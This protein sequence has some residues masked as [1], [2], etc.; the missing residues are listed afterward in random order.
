VIKGLKD[1]QEGEVLVIDSRG[2]RKALTGE[3]FPTEAQRK[4]LAGI[5]IDGPCRDTETVRSLDIPYYARS[6]HCI[7]GTTSRLFETQIPV[8]CG[9]VVVNPG[10]IVFGDDDGLV[11]AT[12][13]EFAAVIPIAEDVQAKEQRLLEEMSKGVSLHDML[14]FDEHC[15][16]IRAGEESQLKF[17]V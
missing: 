10:D 17:L 11:V 16:K 14:N 12:A 13:E 5:V 6:I 7:P 1:A 15:A 4:G 2:S 8:S 3:L 9:G